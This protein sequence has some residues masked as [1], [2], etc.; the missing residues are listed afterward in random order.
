MPD[1]QSGAATP[2]AQASGKEVTDPIT[3]L[4][5]KI[6][7]HESPELQALPLPSESQD[8]SGSNDSRTDDKGPS[9]GRHSAMDDVMNRENL[10]P[11]WQ[12][13][14]T[15]AEKI[16]GSMLA[17]AAA[18][19]GAASSVVLLY[20][21]GT[22]TSRFALTFAMATLGLGAA[23][24]VS[25][26]GNTRRTSAAPASVHEELQNKVI[27]RPWCARFGYLSAVSLR[28]TKRL[29][30]LLSGLT[31]FLTHFGQSS[32][33]PYLLPYPTCLRTLF[34]PPCRK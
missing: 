14:S 16:Q 21:F 20:A 30:S 11:W 27:P 4:P 22:V 15:T 28:V 12:S 34:R 7:D 17:A 19:S 9:D 6:H 2:Q 10:K 33:L 5:L 31:L 29:P 18:T 13:Q 26:I 24:C 32:I 3:H 1:A 25:L 8:S 23:A